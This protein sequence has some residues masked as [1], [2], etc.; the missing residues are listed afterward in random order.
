MTRF[1]W[2]SLAGLIIAHFLLP[3]I[4]VLFWDWPDLINEQNFPAECESFVT[5]G[6]SNLIYYDWQFIF[7]CYDW[8]LVSNLYFVSFFI[9]LLFLS[10]LTLLAIIR[11]VYHLRT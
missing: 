2:L 8:R 6:S 3:A 7:E 9:I 5:G 1:H 10:P 4:V 11:T